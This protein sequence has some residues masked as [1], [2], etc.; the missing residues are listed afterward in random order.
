MWQILHAHSKQN[1]EQ[2]VRD[3]WCACILHNM[4][5]RY[6]KLKRHVG[7][8]L[9]FS[10]WLHVVEEELLE[11][12]RTRPASCKK[13]VSRTSTTAGV[14]RRNALIIEMKQMGEAV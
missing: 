7:L 10:H 12:E 14:E 5:I 6:R 9:E 13:K 3:T 8:D 2:A 1:K 4:L 11:Q